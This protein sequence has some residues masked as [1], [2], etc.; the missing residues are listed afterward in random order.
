MSDEPTHIASIGPSGRVDWRR[1][2]LCGAPRSVLTAHPIQTLL[3]GHGGWKWCGEC[4]V[5]QER[6]V[7]LRMGW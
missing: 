5:K 4:W 1:A 7:R 2:R 3:V 6:L